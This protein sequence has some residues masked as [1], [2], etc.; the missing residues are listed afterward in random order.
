MNYAKLITALKACCLCLIAVLGLHLLSVKSSAQTARIKHV[1]DMQKK[2]NTQYLGRD[3]WFTMSQNYQ[4][5]GGKYYNLYV[6]SPNNTSIFI[7]VTGGTTSKWPITAGQVL[8]FTVPLGWEVTSSGV[9][10][11][12]AV[13]VWSNDADLTAYLLSRNPATSDGM[14]IIPTI[15]W[16]TEYVVAAYESL[17]EGYGTTYDFPSEF[18]IVANQNATICTITPSVD[19]RCQNGITLVH[20]AHQQFTEILN[21]GECVQYKAVLATNCDDYDVSGTLVK[22][23]NPVGIVGASQCPNIPCENPYCD[24]ICEMIPPIRTWANTYLTIPFSTRVAG[25][26]YLIIGSKDGQNIYLNDNGS[27]TNLYCTLPFKYDR[28]L[29]PDVIGSSVWT[30]DAPFMLVQYIN[31]TTYEAQNGGSANGRGDPAMV[32]VNAVEQYTPRVI[33]QTPNIQGSNGFSNYINVMVDSNIST[34]VNTFVDGVPINSAKGAS[35]YPIPGSTYMGWRIANATPG[36]HEIVSPL[37]IGVYVYGYGSYDSYAWAGSLGI[38]TF[39]DPDTIPPV[40][41]TKGICFDAHVDLSDDHI[42]PPASKISEMKVDSIYNMNYD[43]DLAYQA[44]SAMPKTYYDMS[45]VD[46]AKEAY[47]KVETHDFAGNRTTVT[48]TYVPQTATIT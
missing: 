24:H 18:S 15:G 20:K 39:N 37:P 34:I 21:R 26:S 6:T 43:V 45:V 41:V 22:S 46:V 35:R 36:K 10:E 19:L 16:G 42:A 4:N 3:L 25:D 5:Q 31:S 9:V 48:S 33:F 13:R 32:V 12:K 47:L 27:K 28:Y 7:Q 14:L 23:N 29:R 38:R 17:Y 30:S 1:I 2:D 44:G 40:A 8:T 11:P